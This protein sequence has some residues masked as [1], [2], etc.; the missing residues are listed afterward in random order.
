M[1][2]KIEMLKS[3][4]TRGCWQEKQDRFTTCFK[5]LWVLALQKKKSD[6]FKTSG[7]EVK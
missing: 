2:E 4:T 6:S 5:N 7:A 3:S 1:K